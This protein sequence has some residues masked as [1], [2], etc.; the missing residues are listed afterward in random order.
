MSSPPRHGPR[1]CPIH[2][3]TRSTR[4]TYLLRPPPRSRF[5]PR[6]VRPLLVGVPAL[7]TRERTPCTGR[8][9]QPLHRHRL[10]P[11]R[12]QHHLRLRLQPLLRLPLGARPMTLG[13]AWFRHGPC[14]GRL[15]R[16]LVPLRRT[17]APGRPAFAPIL[18]LLASS[19]RVL[20]QTPTTPPRPTTTGGCLTCN[21]S[22]HHC[23]S[24]P[25]CS[26]CLLRLHRFIPRHRL[27][28]LHQAG[29]SLR[30]CR[31]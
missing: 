25:L 16:H 31:P 20:C 1:S 26:W 29:T 3:A 7:T 6:P 18:A 13:P 5:P 9:G 15:P 30:F 24:L 11:P 4:A 8:R 14:R 28:H 12:H 23:T 10:V 21:T 22:I 19:R 2:Q 27:L 17:P